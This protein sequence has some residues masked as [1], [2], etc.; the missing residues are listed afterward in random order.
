MALEAHQGPE[1]QPDYR[2]A[3][4]LAVDSFVADKPV[5]VGRLA[6]AVAVAADKP[7][8][9]ARKHADARPPLARAGY[10]QLPLVGDGQPLPAVDEQPLLVA[11]EQS[12]LVGVEPPQRDRVVV[13]FVL[14]FS[15]RNRDRTCSQY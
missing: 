12:P 8:A 10:E 6:V 5:A 7:A 11:C 14:R 1:D 2:V 3:D 13:G 4:K 9:V 15:D